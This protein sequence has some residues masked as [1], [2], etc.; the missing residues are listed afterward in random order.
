MALREDIEGERLSTENPLS[1][2]YENPTPRIEETPDPIPEVSSSYQV[3]ADGSYQPFDTTPADASRT[4]GGGFVN[5]VNSYQSLV[6]ASGP[7]SIQQMQTA[8]INPQLYGALAFSQYAQPEFANVEAYNYQTEA[9]NPNGG[10]QNLT[11]AVTAPTQAA[12]TNYLERLEDTTQERAAAAVQNQQ[13]W[14][15][16]FMQSP[17]YNANG[18][19]S[20]AIQHNQAAPSIPLLAQTRENG[21]ERVAVNNGNLPLSQTSNVRDTSRSLANDDQFAYN[22][23]AQYNQFL[24]KPLKQNT[25][26]NMAETGLEKPNLRGN[27]NFSKALWR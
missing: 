26:I 27:I 8:N 13:Q 3:N 18:A 14:N 12:T 11:P 9:G 19:N 16:M 7:S 1:Q 23:G 17:V 2:V 22:K 24:N 21:G 4:E 15:S 5:P 25:G 6:D 10:I 20:Y